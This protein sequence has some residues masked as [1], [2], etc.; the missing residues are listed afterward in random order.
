MWERLAELSREFLG[1]DNNRLKL[2]KQELEEI[3]GKIDELKGLVE[4]AVAELDNLATKGRRSEF[5][6]KAS[7]IPLARRI[8]K[9]WEEI[10]NGKKY[11]LKNNHPGG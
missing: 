9:E 1:M 3:K 2:D 7:F 11:L 10:L 8:I 5:S 4:K 6:N